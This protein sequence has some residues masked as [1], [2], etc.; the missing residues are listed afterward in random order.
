MRSR[1]RGYVVATPPGHVHVLA[2]A[3]VAGAARSAI[4][5][6]ETHVAI[7]SMNDSPHDFMRDAALAARHKMG[8]AALKSALVVNKSAG[9]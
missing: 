5:A 9:H 2:Q 8:P 4:A 6:L 3:R 1:L 7:D